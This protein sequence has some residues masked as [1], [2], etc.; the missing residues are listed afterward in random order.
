M[1]CRRANLAPAVF[2]SLCNVATAAML[3]A[4]LV[5]VLASCFSAVDCVA[6]RKCQPG[7]K[8]PPF[9]Q[10]NALG[11]DAILAGVTCQS[12]LPAALLLC[13]L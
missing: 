3:A 5:P 4:R 12:V 8:Q 1:S 6:C 11:E 2:R 13:T 10:H 9:T 7:I